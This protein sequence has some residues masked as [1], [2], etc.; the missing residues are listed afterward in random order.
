MKYQ[1][2]K[3]QSKV[4]SKLSKSEAGISGLAVFEGRISGSR[5]KFGIV[6]SRFNEEITRNLLEGAVKALQASGVESK[7]IE[8]FWCPG[9][10]E[11]P[12]TCRQVLQRK[13]KVDA[14]I[15]L[16]AIIRGETPHFDFVAK[17]A[18]DGVLRVSL[19]EGIPIAF[20]ILTTD[21]PEQALARA[22]QEGENKGKD[23]A[24]CAL[25]MTGLATV[26]FS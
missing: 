18:T 14:L 3:S 9:A 17:A 1:T 21:T 25:E 26:L 15:A 11:I 16:G 19:K 24:L 20:G 12:L 2:T 10:F 8:V 23:A 5:K 13:K 6:V 7:N 22:R 4:T